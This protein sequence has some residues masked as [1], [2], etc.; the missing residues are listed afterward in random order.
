[1]NG[2][3]RE[4]TAASTSIRPRL[5][6]AWR[7]LTRNWAFVIALAL[8]AAGCGSANDPSSATLALDQDGITG[9]ASI[10]PDTVFLEEHPSGEGELNWTDDA[11]GL[12]HDDGH[13]FFTTTQFLLKFS[14]ELDLASTTVFPLGVGFPF[15]QGLPPYFPPGTSGIGP[16]PLASLGYYH[17]GDPDQVGGFLFVPM[18]DNNNDDD[19]NAQPAI[20]VFRASDLGFVG[21]KVTAQTSAAWVAY[22]Q[23]LKYLYSSDDIASDGHPLYR[24][25]LDLDRLAK[26]GDVDGSIT[27]VDH[28]QLLE[29]DG[30]KLDP[31]LGVMQGGVFT[32]WGDL[33]IVNGSFDD[34]PALVR[35]G[36]HL[37]GAGGRLIAESTNGSGTFNYE[38]HPGFTTAEEP[39]GI[40]WWNR[41]IAPPSPLIDGQLHV[42]M[43][44]NDLT[45]Q[46]DM[47][48]KHYTV[49]YGCVQDLDQDGDG[50]TD[51][52]EGYVLGTDPL[53][54]DTDDDGLPDGV[55]VNALRTNP[56]SADS[57]GDGIPDGSEDA[58][59]DG[60][61]NGEE[62]NVYRTDPLRADSDG[63]GLTDGQEVNVYRTDPL[64]ADSD[65]DGLTDGQ[66]VNVYGTDPLRSDSDGDGLNDGL[67]V[68]YGTDPL[69]ADTDGDGLV[70]GKDTEF[71]QHAVE[72]LP[73]SAFKPPGGGTRNATL[74]IL[75]N[76]Q[77][78]A[79]AGD[80]ENAVQMLGNLRRHFDG[81]GTIPGNN[82]WIIDCAHQVTVRDLV[83]LLSTNLTP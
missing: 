74:T 24:Y 15:V 53:D 22:N 77:E 28:F 60:L 14:V 13:W 35:G 12:A 62:V 79:R 48:L 49:R 80:V 59:G 34:D 63:D 55:E 25:K 73:A 66:E 45:S 72:S 38:Y 46:D 11:Q 58:D 70:D 33:Y 9:T 2:P 17:L 41:D 71:I 18:E 75:D 21:L 37:F 27:F 54:A 26:T 57:D 29:A 43:L 40:D 7:G 56:L 36:V 23:H 8:V 5:P 44:D 42:I 30:A 1:M 20:A 3:T 47:F 69:L 83:D 52:Q 32:P 78:R 68:T 19:I 81:C 16:H 67:E 31:P 65:G 61:T 39:E 10:C 51:G 64:R 50:L 76:V 4:L 82:D 6:F